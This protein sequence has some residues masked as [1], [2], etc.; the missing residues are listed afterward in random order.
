VA[1]TEREFVLAISFDGVLLENLNDLTVCP[2][3]PSIGLES[4]DALVEKPDSRFVR[5]I[6]RFDREGIKRVRAQRTDFASASGRTKR[7]RSAGAGGC[8]RGERRHGDDET[9]KKR[10]AHQV[11][12]PAV[13]SF[14]DLAAGN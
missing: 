5:M 3:S 12:Y 8:L 4:Q 6:G 14:A 13:T 2:R 1:R 9:K 10:S 7:F 11:I